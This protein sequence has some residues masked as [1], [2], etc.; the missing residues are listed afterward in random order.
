MPRA[1]VISKAEDDGW[2]L[3]ANVGWFLV[4]NYPAFD[5]RNYGHERFGQLARSADYLDIE[6]EP[7]A[8]GNSRLRGRL[9][10]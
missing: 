8:N 4:G 9:R 2:S 7:A 10:Q 3:L 5:S 6:E 1:A